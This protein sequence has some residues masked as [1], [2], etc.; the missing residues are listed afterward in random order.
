MI[1]NVQIITVAVTISVSIVVTKR[2]IQ[3]DPNQKQYNQKIQVTE[4]INQSNPQRNNWFSDSC[5][6]MWA[7]G[8]AAPCTFL[9]HCHN[10]P[11]NSRYDNYDNDDCHIDSR[12]AKMLWLAGCTSCEPCEV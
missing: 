12:S 11:D 1:V 10:S 9:L 3:A 2:D 6:R 7:Y 5:V 4:D 8:A